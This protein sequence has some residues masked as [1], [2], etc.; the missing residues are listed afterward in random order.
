[1]PLPVLPNNAFRSV[2]RIP[3]VAQGGTQS[4]FSY[5]TQVA[6][7]GG[8]AWSYEIQFYSQNGDDGR[9]LAAF[10][11][12]L[13]G[14]S[15]TFILKDPSGFNS[16]SLGTPLV[17]GASQSGY[18]LITD[19]WTPSIT[20]LKAGYFIQLGTD[21]TSRL[22]MVTEDAT[23]DGSG[24]ATLTIWPAIRETPA[25]NAVIVTDE[26]GVVLRLDGTP[27]H[28]IAPHADFSFTMTAT[29]VI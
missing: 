12:N 29:E 2:Q 18:S 5:E 7:W 13:K 25:D 19:G 11:T 1:M 10:F 23:S 6:D 20:V 9:A 26:P 24:N 4:P 21:D 22:H 8:E 14:R 17:N 15:G 16:A 3:L 28:R 27:P